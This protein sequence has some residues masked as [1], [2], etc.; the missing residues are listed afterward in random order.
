M[1]TL[2]TGDKENKEE[3]LSKAGG[4]KKHKNVTQGELRH[5]NKEK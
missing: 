1:R 3:G 4:G 2:T 5:N